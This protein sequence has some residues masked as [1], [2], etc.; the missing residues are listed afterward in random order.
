MTSTLD[1]E[2]LAG[3]YEE[4]IPPGGDEFTRDYT[5]PQD[6]KSHTTHFM[7]ADIGDFLKRPKTAV[8]REYEK[9][10]AALLN[11]GMRFTIKSPETLPD[12]AAIIAY[13]DNV[14]SAAGELAESDEWTRK[15]ID[16]IAVPGDPR[17]LFALALI[18]LASQIFRNHHDAR[19][20]RPAAGIEGPPLTR[21]Q[22]RAARK[23]R[24]AARPGINV[25]VG[26]FKVKVPFSVEML[27]VNVSRYAMSQSVEPQALSDAVFSNPDI[28]KA[29]KK[30]GINIGA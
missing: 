20:S 27:G 25:G 4:D 29:L 23:Q 18:P 30:R 6:E 10:T 24:R 12:A 2:V 1:D 17:I 28:L 7:D 9:K 13:G 16:L 21:K 15:A 19:V 22:K 8:A 11:A 14:A 3:E 26:R 5:P